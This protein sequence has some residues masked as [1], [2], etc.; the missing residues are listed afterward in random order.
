MLIPRITPSELEDRFDV[1]PVWERQPGEGSVYLRTR[2]WDADDLDGYEFDSI[3]DRTLAAAPD[4]VA[5]LDG[6]LV[7]QPRDGGDR[8]GDDAAG[9]RLLDELARD[10]AMYGMIAAH[11]PGLAGVIEGNQALEPAELIALVGRVHDGDVVNQLHLEYASPEAAERNAA[12]L[13][14][15]LDASRGFVGEVTIEGTHVSARAESTSGETASID[16][17][18]RDQKRIGG[19]GTRFDLIATDG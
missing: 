6:V 18:F 16:E 11:E 10:G 17:V 19:S 2:A 15:N 9:R 12:A 7:I 4:R 14:E 3:V 8:L 1:S 5:V 13:R